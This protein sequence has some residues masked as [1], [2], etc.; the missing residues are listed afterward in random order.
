M[1][2]NRSNSLLGDIEAEIRKRRSEWFTADSSGVA[3]ISAVAP[4]DQLTS[5]VQ[6]EANAKRTVTR[7]GRAAT[8]DARSIDTLGNTERVFATDDDYAARRSYR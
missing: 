3:P 7:C 2:T 6:I 5:W 4:G 8:K 1:F